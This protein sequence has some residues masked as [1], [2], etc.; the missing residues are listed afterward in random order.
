M[1]ETSVSGEIW[2]GLFYLYLTIA[3][4]VGALVLGWLLYSLW[5][6]RAR[7]GVAPP[8]DHPKPGHLSRERG[9]PVWSYVMAIIIAGIMF[10]LAFGTINAI[11]ELET[12]PPEGTNLHVNVTGFQFGWRVNYTG[13]GG[14]NVARANEW[15][16]PVDVPV[17]ANVTSQ[18][19]WHNFAIP[20]FRIRIDAIPGQTNHIWFQAQQTGDYQPVCVQLCGV[21]HALMKSKMH[22]VSQA[23]FDKYLAAESQKEYDRFFKAGRN[24][25]N[26]TWDGQSFTVAGAKL[27]DTRPVAVNLT[28]NGQETQVFTLGAYNITLN[29]GATGGLFAQR[30]DAAPTLSAQGTRQSVDLRTVS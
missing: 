24:V 19:V 16:V 4:V 9:H 10:G 8:P 7:P 17:V 13:T 30:I 20:D 18:D 3:L 15:T 11:H 2:H 12:P 21:G 14:I 26:A 5:R 25:V 23:D 22:V 28:N 1:A 6:F 29:P 27:D